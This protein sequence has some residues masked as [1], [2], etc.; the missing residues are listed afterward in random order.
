[1][2]RTR[3]CTFLDTA[4]LIEQPQAHKARAPPLVGDE[5]PALSGEFRD[6][7]FLW[8]DFFLPFIS[9]FG[10]PNPDF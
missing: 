1:V 6:L 2:G 9:L 5:P 7:V 4:Q 8:I 10:F 3:I